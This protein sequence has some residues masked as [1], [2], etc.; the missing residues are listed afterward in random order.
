MYMMMKDGLP[1][2]TPEKKGFRLFVRTLQ[3]L[4]KAPSEPT[5][6][7]LL[8]EKYDVL[9]EDVG[10]LMSEAKHITL[11]CDIWTQ[12]GTMKGF[13]GLTAHFCI[14]RSYNHVNTPR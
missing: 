10:K 14:G 13:L 8:E 7:K 2:D 9:R 5:L 1:L 11:T 12:K 6:T 3:P 4:Y